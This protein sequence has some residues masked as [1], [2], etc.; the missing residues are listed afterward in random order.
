M[1]PAADDMTK[2]LLPARLWMTHAGWSQVSRSH[3][4][5]GNRAEPAPS[6]VL[7]LGRA[8]HG[9]PSNSRRRVRP[10]CPSWGAPVSTVRPRQYLPT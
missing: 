2:P 7:F 10:S 9:P 8:A 4:R 6:P 3:R 1:R 5:G